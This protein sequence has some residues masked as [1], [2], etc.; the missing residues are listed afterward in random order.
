MTARRPATADTA[1]AQRGRHAGCITTNSEDLL[2][3][4]SSPV[5]RTSPRRATRR[6][7]RL[8]ESSELIGQHP[9]RPP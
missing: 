4:R 3:R 1:A 2:R 7:D 8:L 6:R 5:A 9:L